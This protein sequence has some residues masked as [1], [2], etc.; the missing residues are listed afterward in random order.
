M[1][2]NRSRSIS[3]EL[4]KAK[5]GDPRRA[6]RLEQM[7]GAMLARP[8]ASL[9]EAMGTE[10]ALEGAYR[11]LNNDDVSWQGILLPHTQATV[12]RAALARTIYAISDTTEL[13]FGGD[14]REGL[15]P[16][17]G[18]GHGFLAHV[19][20]AV[21]ADGSR[22][23]LGILAMEPIVRSVKKKARRGTKK[24]RRSDDRESLKWNRVAL[25][26]EQ[27]VG[28]RASVIHVMDREADVYNL[29]GQFRN[30]ASR[31]VV[32]VAQD[33]KLVADAPEQLFAAIQRGKVRVTREV[34]LTRRVRGTKGHPKRAG[35]PAVLSISA[36]T[37]TIRRPTTADPS[38][39]ESLTLNFVHVFEANPP[40][41]EAAI[42]WKLVTSEPID[43]ID[44]LEAVVDAYRARWVIEELF[45]A[46]KTGCGF[47]KY[48]IE[49]LDALLNLLAIELPVACQLFALRSLA[50][51]TPNAPASHV[52]S[53]VQLRVLR[54]MA[55]KKLAARA[56]VSDAM[57]AIASL[58]GYLKHNGPP[59]W[60]VL[61]RGFADLMRY[62]E[63][64]IAMEYGKSRDQS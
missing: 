51:A 22:L 10:A 53:S 38:L 19:C 35:R 3:K 60:Q 57:A 58:G 5:L 20:L 28:G 63:V 44:A 9:P 49:S 15:G 48:Q 23:P 12:E 36:T 13:R 17:Q 52:L 30:C 47:E 16:L 29:F 45:K 37:A 24:S 39:P 59:G 11:F 40:E 8:A 43:S 61:G 2:K 14:V 25:A 18:R 4:G 41:G 6:L 1:A 62:T 33:R 26:A 55:R 32:R 31:F 34:P 27:A 50:T 46:L 56:T 7:A 54:V 42:D 21:A 64:V